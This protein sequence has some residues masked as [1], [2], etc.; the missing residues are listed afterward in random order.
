MNIRSVFYIANII[1]NNLQ[2]FSMYSDSVIE[3]VYYAIGIDNNKNIADR[4]FF[5]I[6][7]Q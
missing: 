7:L 4:F 3:D 2:K 1:L 6:S 5:Q